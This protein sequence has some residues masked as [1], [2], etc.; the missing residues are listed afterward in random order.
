MQ[1]FNQNQRGRGR[2][3]DNISSTI[4]SNSRANNASVLQDQYLHLASGLGRNHIASTE[5]LLITGK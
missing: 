2:R 5:N 1:R 4:S 3:G